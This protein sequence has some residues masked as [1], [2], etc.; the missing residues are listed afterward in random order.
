MPHSIPNA[1][2]HLIDIVQPFQQTKRQHIP[3]A[4]FQIQLKAL[5][6]L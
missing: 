6:A 5:W 1:L 3:L 4:F 2:G